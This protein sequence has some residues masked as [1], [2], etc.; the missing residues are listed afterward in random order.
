MY[1]DGTV[2]LIA[3]ELTSALVC[4]NDVGTA[5]AERTLRVSGALSDVLVYAF[6]S[7]LAKA[8]GDRPVTVYVVVELPNASFRIPST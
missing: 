2:Q 8:S 5:G 6:T 7:T 4:V 3:T 1:T